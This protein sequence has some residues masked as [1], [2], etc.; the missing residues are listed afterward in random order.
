MESYSPVDAVTCTCNV[1]YGSTRLWKPAAKVFTPSY[2]GTMQP[3]RSIAV[4][5][6]IRTYDPSS[7]NAFMYI[8]L[9]G[10]KLRNP[11]AS[12]GNLGA[13][14]LHWSYFVWQEE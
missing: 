13:Y 12:R 11:A 3:A 7:C 2:L 14:L 10:K 8:Q 4:L 1:G 9:D 6:D 5:Q